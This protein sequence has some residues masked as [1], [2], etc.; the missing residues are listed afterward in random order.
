MW[1]LILEVLRFQK[2]KKETDSE[3]FMK[4]VSKLTPWEC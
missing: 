4:K 3:V 1:A 2:S